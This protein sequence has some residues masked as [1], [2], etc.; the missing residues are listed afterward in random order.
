MIDQLLNEMTRNPDFGFVVCTLAITI[1]A[2]II[3]VVS[4]LMLD[5]RKAKKKDKQ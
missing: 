3:G 4:G 1:I 5:R 2:S